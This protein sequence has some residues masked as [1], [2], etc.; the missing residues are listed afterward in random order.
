MTITSPNQLGDLL[1]LVHDRWFNVERVALDKE[2][3]TV[4]MHLEANKANLA[5]GS[6]DGIRLFIKNA[7]ALAVNDT[8]KVRDYDLS[9]IKFDAASGRVIITGGIPITIEVKVTALDIEANAASQLLVS[10]Q[11]V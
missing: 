6:A 11:T 4:A 5:K 2:H 3:K 7:E 10:R 1:N 9:E 8:E